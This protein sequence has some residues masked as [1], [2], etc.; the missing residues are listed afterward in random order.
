MTK[1]QAKRQ[2]KP[3]RHAQHADA[4]QEDKQQRLARA[5]RANLRK[6]KDKERMSRKSYLIKDA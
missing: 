6:R 5:L 2:D 1:R 4:V 3:L